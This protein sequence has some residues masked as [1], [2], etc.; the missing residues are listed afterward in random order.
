M[1]L[2]KIFLLAL[3]HYNIISTP[4]KNPPE[5]Q[6]QRSTLNDVYYV[7]DPELTKM[8]RD[9]LTSYLRGLGMEFDTIIYWA[10]K[11]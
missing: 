8:D 6:Y 5:L 4:R 7:S 11:F 1:E 2:A 9:Q 10:E 3:V